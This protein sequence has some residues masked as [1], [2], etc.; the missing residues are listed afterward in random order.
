MRALDVR[1]ER[2]RQLS[3]QR[4]PGSS[5]GPATLVPSSAAP[6]PPAAAADSSK[7]KAGGGASVDAALHELS[8]AA[9]RAVL[10]VV[11]Y[12]EVRK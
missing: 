3:A 6:A 7:G 5:N 10:F 9:Y 4:R 12:T 8:T 11:Y 2:E 1:A